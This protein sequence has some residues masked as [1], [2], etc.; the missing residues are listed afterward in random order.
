VHW[1]KWKKV[2]NHKL[3]GGMG[4]RDLRAFNEALLAKQGW[5]L[6]TNPT[7]L[8]AQ[9]LQAKYYADSSFLRAKPKQQMSY[10]WRSI[11]SASWILKKGC[12]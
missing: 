2:S 8:V 7:S 5:R 1:V 9:V 11:L 12:Y 3:K 10:S 4:F 6:L